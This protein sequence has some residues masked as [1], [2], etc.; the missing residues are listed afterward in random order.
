MTPINI[1]LQSITLNIEE[2]INGIV[3]NVLAD[4]IDS[5]IMEVLE[6]IMDVIDTPDENDD[7]HETDFDQVVE[8]VIDSVSPIVCGDE[9]SS[10]DAKPSGF[11]PVEDTVTS[12]GRGPLGDA[13]QD[14]NEGRTAA[15]E[16]EVFNTFGE[17]VGWLDLRATP[18]Q[19]APRRRNPFSETWRSVKRVVRGLCCCL[20][21]GFH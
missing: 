20:G 11:Q 1:N 17:L 5:S 3:Q 13:A 8:E 16:A 18:V 9:M 6:E 2:E 4:Y 10:G 12:A 7:L 14:V 21:E 15:K 19:R